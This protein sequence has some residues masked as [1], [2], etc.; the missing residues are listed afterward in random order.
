LRCA[1][2]SV[3]AMGAGMWMATGIL[4]ALLERGKSGV[5]QLVDASLFQS[6]I[7]AMA[8]YLVYRQFLGR[9]PVPQGSTHAAFAPYSAFETA[10]GGIMIGC[11]NDRLF[12]RLCTAIDRQDWFS[13]PRFATNVLRVRNRGDLEGGLQT[14]FKEKP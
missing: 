10:D 11:S 14:I 5:G 2:V 1:G 13:D 4:A 8:Y 3:I 6:G 7:M 12:R 9:D